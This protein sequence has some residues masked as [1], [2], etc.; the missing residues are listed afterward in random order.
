[1]CEWIMSWT[2]SK[3][4]TCC[5]YWKHSWNVRWH[6]E[7]YRTSPEND[8]IYKRYLQ[9]KQT[10]GVMGGTLFS[11]ERCVSKRSWFSTTVPSNHGWAKLCLKYRESQQ[12]HWSLNQLKHQDLKYTTWSD[13][14]MQVRCAT[15]ILWE[16]WT[17]FNWPLS[18]TTSEKKPFYS[19]FLLLSIKYI[20]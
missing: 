1:M 3:D 14:D 13:Q 20:S 4:W 5:K 17:K 18:L 16:W 12:R 15:E 11:S 9:K 2:L 6:Q 19:F 8:F 7:N 10:N